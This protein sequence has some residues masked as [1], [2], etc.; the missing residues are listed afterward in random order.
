MNYH[1]ELR[2]QF[3]KVP[4]PVR[5]GL[6]DDRFRPIGLLT[7]IIPKVTK[8][9]LFNV[10][11]DCNCPRAPLC[12]LIALGT[13]LTLVPRVSFLACFKVDCGE[14]N[15]LQAVAAL[16]PGVSSMLHRR[17][18]HREYDHYAYQSSDQSQPTLSSVTEVRSVRI[19]H[20]EPLSEAYRRT[21]F[22]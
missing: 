22:M 8:F 11:Q 10:R 18:Q 16:G 12:S 1:A 14:S 20:H 13:K 9:L 15:V 17:C 21:L 3:T 5:T 19:G 6:L 4:S 7:W 2:F